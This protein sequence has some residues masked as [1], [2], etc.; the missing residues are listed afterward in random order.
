MDSPSLDISKAGFSFREDSM[1]HHFYYSKGEIT[2]KLP[3]MQQ[4]STSHGL[5]DC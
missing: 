1:P 2:A 3:E 5:F 4:T